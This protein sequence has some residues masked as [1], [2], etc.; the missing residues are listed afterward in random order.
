MMKIKRKQI[1][2]LMKGTLA[3]LI[4]SST[5]SFGSSALAAGNA[6]IKW[7]T[8][9]QEIDGFGVS[10]AFHQAY[11]L[12]QSSPTVQNEVLDLLFSTT[13]GVGLSII[14]NDIGDGGVWNDVASWPHATIEPTEGNYNTDVLNDDQLWF[15]NEGKKRGVDRF[16]STVWSPPGWMKTNGKVEEGGSLRPDK[17][18]AFADYLTRYIKD[19]K[20]KFGIDIYAIS[21]ANEPNN[22]TYYSSNE[23][24]G[25]QFRDFIKSNLIPTFDNNNITSKV[26]L[27]ETAE[28]DESI[29]VPALQDA[30]AGSRVDITGVHAY[31]A[32]V[33]VLPVSQ[34]KNKKVWQ[35]E[36]GNLGPNDNSLNDQLFW[37][38]LINS[39]MLSNASAWMYWWGVTVK[40]NGEALVNN[41]NSATNTYTICKRVY[42][43]GNYSRFIRPGYVRISVNENPTNDV[44]VTAYKNKSDGKFVVVAINDSWSDQS[45]NFSL[46]GFTA[47]TVTPYR[48][49][50]TE[51]LAQLANV[52]VTNGNTLSPTLKARSITTFVGTATSTGNSG[53]Q[54]F[55]DDFESNAIGS[56]AAGWTTDGGTWQVFQPAGNTKEYRKT[57]TGDNTSI[58]GSNWSNYSVQ[59]YIKLNDITNGGASLLGRVQDNSHYYQLEL[60]KDSS[61]MRKWWIWKNNGGSWTQIA[62]GYYPYEADKYYLIKLDMNGSNLTA[63]ISTNFGSTFTTLGYG[64]DSQYSSGKIGVRSWGTGGAF[65]AIRVIANN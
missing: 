28:W 23:W 55:Y 52:S 56:N 49:S 47:S 3:G 22:K 54:L 61:G 10:G 19:Y 30:T 35:T 37:A 12:Q 2:R 45:L 29:A 26:I 41:L 60:K 65:D 11:H 17:Y 59:G 62:S 38:K 21:L 36:V 7:N 14:R 15:M 18:Q 53:A 13:N 1:T 44:Y 63:S 4:L 27:G 33:G 5:L 46:D 25:A 57:S 42:A 48:T 40:D 6:T 32:G 64:Q 58:A 39:H 50:E 20:S 16:F 9:Y 51:Q 43:I 8:E 34:S 31:D 24:T